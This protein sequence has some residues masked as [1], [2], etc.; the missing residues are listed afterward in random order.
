[1]GACSSSIER[2]HALCL[3]PEA[4]IRLWKAAEGGIPPKFKSSVFP[5]KKETKMTRKTNINCTES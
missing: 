3:P 1:M 2:T 5:V 4:Y